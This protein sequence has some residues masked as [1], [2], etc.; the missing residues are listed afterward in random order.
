M[1]KSESSYTLN[2]DDIII[3]FGMS[4]PFIIIAY[5]IFT[6]LGY[7]TSSNS[8]SLSI[9]ILII[10]GWLLLGIY[11]VVIPSKS[12]FISVL[13][14]TANH[15]LAGLSCI[16]ITNL[17]FMLWPILTMANYVYFGKKG[18]KYNILAYVLIIFI[19]IIIHFDDLT[20]IITTLSTFVMVIV[21]SLSLL[22]ISRTH[23]VKQERLYKSQLKESIERDRMA[24][25]VNNLSD[26]VISVDTYGK[27]K[28]YN[29]E[30]S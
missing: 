27:I 19:E 25:I 2:A 4:I 18:I 20:Y 17:I 3:K 21:T 22:T 28:V 16:L 12:A 29:L 8:S 7:M 1:Y 13:R 11:Q 15:I 14:L 10:I 6:Q 23:E 30:L 9:Y 5:I 26:S 24:A